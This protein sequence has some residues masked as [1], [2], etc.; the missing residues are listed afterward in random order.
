M[1]KAR[2][3]GKIIIR[4]VP[5]SIVNGSRTGFVCVS[6]SESDLWYYGCYDTFERASEVAF[7]LGNGMVIEVSNDNSNKKD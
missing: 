6:V 7:E 2:I 3:E 5:E 4:N 1:I